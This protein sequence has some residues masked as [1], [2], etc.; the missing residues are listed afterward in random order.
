MNLL[1]RNFLDKFTCSPRSKLKACKLIYALV[2]TNFSDDRM[3]LVVAPLTSK[4]KH[5]EL[6]EAPD[7]K[8]RREQNPLS[9][10][11]ARCVRFDLV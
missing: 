9:W 8:S 3:L 2:L 7:A 10:S 11:H 5:L 1:P 6:E 4:K